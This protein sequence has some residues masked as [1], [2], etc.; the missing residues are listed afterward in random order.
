MGFLSVTKKF[1][2]LL[3]LAS[4][5][6]FAQNIYIETTDYN[7]KMDGVVFSTFEFVDASYSKSRATL[8]IITHK[9]ILAELAVSL[10]KLRG[11]KKEYTD[12]W[13]LGID[14]TDS[15][16]QSKTDRKI[17]EAFYQKI[18]KYRTD[19]DL[20]QY[21]KAQLENLTVVAAEK[22][23]VCQYLNCRILKL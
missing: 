22:A 17:I 11:T 3:T 12:Y 20:P 4:T 14:N 18:Q 10:P 7:Q 23:A 19:D 2:L 6:G 15:K 9:E 5:S 16:N 1:V 8:V 21:S 13:I